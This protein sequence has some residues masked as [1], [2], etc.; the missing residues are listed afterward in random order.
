MAIKKLNPITAGMRFK[1]SPTFEELTRTQPEKL[2]LRPLKKGGGRNNKGR[3]TARHRG[4]GHK[5]RYRL[6][7][8][9]RNK[10]GIPAKVASIEYDPNRSARIAL[11]NYADGEKRY[12]ISP[13]GLKVGE[14]I[15]SGPQAEIKVGNFLPLIRIPLGTIVHNVELKPGNRLR[16]PGDGQGGWL[17]AVEASL[18]G[19]EK[20]SL[21]MWGHHRDRGKPRS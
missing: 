19:G 9:R 16:G 2:L 7:D 17:G 6:I 21:S 14:T 15:N 18:R 3:V 1:T 5:R 4:G 13:L 12:I 10:H 11:L 20:L 8:F